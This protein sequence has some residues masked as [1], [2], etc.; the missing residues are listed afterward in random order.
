MTTQDTQ[1][2]ELI[3]KGLYRDRDELS[4]KLTEV[5]KLIKKIKS[6]TFS[7]LQSPA[8]EDTNNTELLTPQKAEIFP[9]KAEMKFQLLAI[10]DMLG[11]ACKLKDIQDK[12]T[13]L[14]GSKYS[15]RETLRT[16]NKHNVIKLLRPIEGGRGLYWVKAEWLD[17]DNKLIDKYKFYGFDML[18]KIEC[19]EFV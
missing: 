3:L 19:I 18:Y 2:K 6:N 13:E 7:L 8:I 1:E 9:F 16:L 10:I 14:T 4:T 15:V 11:V 5:E 17:D 12:Y